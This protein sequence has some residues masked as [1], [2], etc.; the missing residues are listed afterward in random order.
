MVGGAFDYHP[1]NQEVTIRTVD[2]KHP[3]VAAFRGKE[4][5]VHR[6]EPYC[7]NIGKQLNDSA[8]TKGEEEGEQ[9]G[10]YT[11]PEPG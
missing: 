3:L 2:E 1:P 10:G 6:D 8:S 4:P 5:F 11:R 9:G 7:F